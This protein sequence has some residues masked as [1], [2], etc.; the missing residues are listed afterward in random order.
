MTR[1][2]IEAFL[3]A[4]PPFETDFETAKL[5]NEP[6][7]FDCCS[8]P[9]G[10]VYRDSPMF[11]EDVL[12]PRYSATSCVRCHIQDGRGRFPE[13]GGDLHS[14]VV[15]LGIPG[16]GPNGEPL[17]HPLYGNQF[18]VDAVEGSQPEGRVSVDWEFIDG[19]FD[20]GTPYQLRRPIYTF[21]DTAY[22]SIGTNVPDEFSTPGYEGVAVVSARMTPMLTG[23]GLLGAVTESAILANLDPNDSDG[24]GISGRRNI[25]WDRTLGAHVTGRFGWK[26][27]QPSLIQQAAK[28]FNHDMGMTNPVYPLVD[29][30]ESQPGCET[31]PAAPEVGG[32]ELSLVAE[33]LHGLTPPPRVNYEDPDAISGMY[34]FKEA[35]CSAC[36]VPSLETN[37][38][39]PIATYRGQAIEAFTDLLLHDMGEEL[40]DGREEFAASPREWRTAPLWAL[41]YVKYALGY[42]EH[43]EDPWSGGA[44]PNFLHDGRARS[45][46]EAILWHGGEAAASRDH[47]LAMNA[48]ERQALVRYVEYPFNDP[49]FQEGDPGS[50]PADLSGDGVV[51]GIDLGLMLGD[52]A[53]NGP[54]DISG[55]GVVNGQ[56]MGMLLSAWG[57]C[58]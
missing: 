45:I 17:A 13:P 51:D 44:E 37:Q 20:D 3:E 10:V 23:V 26:A 25:V 15:A 48:S 38:S 9:L 50:C 47:V 40:A 57:A 43:C 41:G 27:G 16:S 14:V 56:D 5:L 12:G 2:Q 8:G 52:W 11:R 18:D 54:G 31:T 6:N 32:A 53:N 24:D 49:I 22:G 4:K 28:A 55:D 30:G 7:R 29:C 1:E 19:A 33:Y 46:M 35:N 21:R 58:N 42:P 39:D 36:H 34:L